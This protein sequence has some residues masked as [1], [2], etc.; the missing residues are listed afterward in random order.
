MPGLSPIHRLRL[1]AAR[2]LWPVVVLVL[3]VVLGSLPVALL[4]AAPSLTV[5]PNSGPS[6]TLAVLTGSGWSFGE[7]PYEV[8]WDEEGGF[9]FGA[10]APTPN[11]TWNKQITIP[12]KS[13]PGTHLIV[14]CQAYATKSQVC[15]NAKFVVPQL[16]TSTPTNTPTSVPTNTPTNTPTATPT[17]A[18]LTSTATA[19]STATPTSTPTATATLSPTP[20]Q[21]NGPTPT[22]TP[23]PTPTPTRPPTATQTPTNTPTPLPVTIRG[24][25]GACTGAPAGAHVLTFDTVVFDHPV[26]ES[27]DSYAA[28]EFT[29]NV[30]GTGAG[31]A[32]TAGAY[33]ERPSAASGPQYGQARAVRLVTSTAEPLAAASWSTVGMFVALPAIEQPFRLTAYDGFGREVATAEAG[34]HG[35]ALDWTCVSVTAPGIAAVRMEP[36]SSFSGLTRFDDFFFIGE[37]LPV[38][39]HDE[40]EITSPADGFT[41]SRLFVI[42]G[43]LFTNRPLA[44][45]DLSVGPMGTAADGA[46]FAFS[47]AV[48]A[49]PFTSTSVGPASLRLE[50]DPASIFRYRFT[51]TT[52]RPPEGTHL[53]EAFLEDGLLLER[54]IVRFAEDSVTIN[55][56]APTPTPTPTAT[57][58]PRTGPFNMN[59]RAIEVTQGVRGDIPSRTVDTGTV[60]FETTTHVADRTTIVRVYPWLQYSDRVGFAMNAQLRGYRDGVELPGS[61]LTPVAPLPGFQRAWTLGDLRGN[62]ARSW[63]FRLPSSWTTAG[64]I[65]LRVELDPPGTG[66]V[67]ECS[68]VRGS[69]PTGAVCGGDADNNATLNNVRFANTNGLTFRMITALN[70][71]TSTTGSG[72]SVGISPSLTEL[73]DMMDWLWKVYPIPDLG[74]SVPSIRGVAADC[75]G[76][77]GDCDELATAHTVARAEVARLGVAGGSRTLFPIVVGAGASRGCSGQAGLPNPVYWQGACGPTFAQETFHAGGG[78][79]HAGNSHGEA[80]GGG[81]NPAY[82]NAHGA[83]EANTYGFDLLALQAIPPTDSCGTGHTHDFMSYGCD[84]W[85]SLYTWQQIQAWLSAAPDRGEEP[86][87]RGLVASAAPSRLS[88]SG[89]ALLLSGAVS[90]SG[91]VTLSVPI[92]VE[93]APNSAGGS[94]RLGIELLDSSGTVLFSRSVEPEPLLHAP[95]GS[96]QFSLLL[97]LLPA[98]A[99]VRVSRDGVTAGEV[100]AGAAIEAAR[101]VGQSIPGTVAATGELTIEWTGTAPGLTYTLEAGPDHEG[102]WRSL[103]RT[104][105]T[106]I[107]LALA[108]LPDDCLCRLRLQ[109]SDGVNVAV[110]ESTAVAT[111][112]RAPQPAIVAPAAGFV[113]P[114]VSTSLVGTNFGPS[115]G[116]SFEWLA[117]DAVVGT[118]A[119]AEIE[120]LSIGRH[121]IT[122]RVTRAGLSAETAIEVE[123]G[124]DSDGDGLPDAWESKHGLDPGDAQDAALDNDGDHLANWQELGYGTRPDSRDSDGD[125]YADDVEIA[126]G[127]DPNDA[128]SVPHAI[129]GV[130]GLGVPR[131]SSGGSALSRWWWAYLLAGASG[132]GLLFGWRWRAHRRSA[133]APAAADDSTSPEDR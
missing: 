34:G 133:A 132:P 92:L 4:H 66:H 88:T 69:L 107:T 15:T 130:E 37:E 87:E 49:G 17:T 86:A 113:R 94:G 55:Y 97:P 68:T 67:D 128:K 13:S 5:S 121:R 20:F 39:Y 102:N 120:P 83:V 22:S 78:V 12:G 18:P 58:T 95:A 52:T 33:L 123:V 119:S 80:A 2:R 10:F 53:Y 81:F 116:A 43:T 26:G 62:A 35:A 101:F 104:T 111:A 114:G 75:L 6:L 118:G 7:S 99:R 96:A 117:D 73:V 109:A 9:S 40:L 131:L 124:S 11:G 115:D 1:I 21:P 42:E 106:R 59:V 36:A 100:R 127:G 28:V 84:K 74:I 25:G 56:A 77:I 48:G 103:G 91:A 108:S 98:V 61:P 47:T 3:V 54:D 105:A 112:A 51:Y 90:P 44:R 57:A 89:E 122:L 19:T 38:P 14:A 30:L 72:A 29:R 64:A 65:Q 32:L 41:T 76:T 71:R 125:H 31:H 45:V 8:F 23:T 60:L 46:Y 70:H 24:S 27:E 50:R 79:N 93:A 129:H 110:T 85:V 82:P 63:N 126:G 16:P